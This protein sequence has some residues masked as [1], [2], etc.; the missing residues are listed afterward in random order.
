MED[1]ANSLMLKDGLRFC[2]PVGLSMWPVWS[3]EADAMADA[4]LATSR[5]ALFESCSQPDRSAWILAHFDVSPHSLVGN[6]YW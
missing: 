6:C 4:E 3:V 1:G 2:L 5:A